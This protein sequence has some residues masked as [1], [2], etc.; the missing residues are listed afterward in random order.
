METWIWLTAYVVGFGL[1][2]V[3]LYRYVRRRDPSPETT[4]GGAERADAGGQTTTPESA[5]DAA[6]AVTCRHCGAENEAHA[7]VNYCRA[8]AESLR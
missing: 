5:G 7:M 3:L 6:G 8:C 2:Q 1:L 4:A